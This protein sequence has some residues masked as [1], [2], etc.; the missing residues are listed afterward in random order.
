GIVVGDP[1]TQ[2][3]ANGR[4]H[5]YSDAIDGKSHSSFGWRECVSENGLFA[6]LQS[7]SAGALKDAKDNE[8]WEIG[9]EPTQKRTDGKKHDTAH[10]EAL[11]SHNRREPAAQWQ[12]NRVGY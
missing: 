1:S 10:I 2:R 5:Y 7:A 12:N 6:G 11:A 8:H 3:G 4:S 9:C